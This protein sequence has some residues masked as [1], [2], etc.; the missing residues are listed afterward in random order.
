MTAI[1]EAGIFEDKHIIDAIDRLNQIGRAVQL[2][3]ILQELH[4]HGLYTQFDDYEPLHV[5]LYEMYHKKLLAWEN[6]PETLNAYDII[7]LK[8]RHKH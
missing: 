7:E 2:S 3:T 8:K 6:A 5:K 4:E 1:Y